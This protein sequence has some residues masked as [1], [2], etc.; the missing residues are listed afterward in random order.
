MGDDPYAAETEYNRQHGLAGFPMPPGGSGGGSAPINGTDPNAPQ[1]YNGGAGFNYGDYTQGM[2]SQNAAQS[3]GQ[4]WNTFQDPNTRQ[5]SSAIGGMLDQRLQGYGENGNT[6]SLAGITTLGATHNANAANIDTGQS[7]N[8]MGGQVANINALNAQA[9]GQGPS[10]AAETARQQG[11]ANTRAQMSVLGSQRGAANSALGQRAAQDSAAQQRQGTAQNAAMGRAQEAMSARQQLTGALGG[12]TQQ[13]QQGAQAQAGLSQQAGM[14]NAAAANQSTLQQ[15]SM[16]QQTALA[17]MQ[18]RLQAGQ[19]NMQQYNAFVQATLSQN[20]NDWGARM[21][22][23]NDLASNALQAQGIYHNGVA[24]AGPANSYGMTSAG[25]G[26][27]AS[28]LGAATT[29]ASD[30]RL[31]TGIRSATRGI[32][33]FLSQYGSGVS[34]LSLMG[35]PP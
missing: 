34:A 15:G 24:V 19:I 26:A 23:A 31:K 10:V 25:I 14:A 35:A 30:V 32:K 1:A 5:N 11:E 9:Q 8:F 29:A 27:G 20:N 18:A 6:S 21:N 3:Q 13:A 12:A 28:V 7:Q 2:G 17:N 16:D 22:A 33:D 4:F